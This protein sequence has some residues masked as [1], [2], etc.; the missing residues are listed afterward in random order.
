MD[1][2][3]MTVFPFLSDSGS[4]SPINERLY[5]AL[6]NNSP[7]QEVEDALTAGADPNILFNDRER[8][9]HLAVRMFRRE[10]LVA[11]LMEA[12]ADP[13]GLNVLGQ[14]PA[15]VTCRRYDPKNWA[16]NAARQI[17]N[18]GPQA[19]AVQFLKDQ[20][21][22]ELLF[23]NGGDVQTPCPETGLVPVEVFPDIQK[24]SQHDLEATELNA[25]TV[26]ANAPSKAG[27]L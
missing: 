4:G 25:R 22:V 15:H 1:R 3:L 27:R 23:Q 17:M 5:Q 13:N 9:L 21:A 18:L 26:E 14:T 2:A 7:W 8:P 24:I 19:E 20:R 12:G 6:S 16:S 10:K 11:I